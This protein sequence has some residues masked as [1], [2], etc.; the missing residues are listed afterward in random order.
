MSVAKVTEISSSSTKSFEDAI[1]QGIERSK[2]TLRNISGAWISEQKVVV[3]AGKITH[4]RV[5]M[6]V[7]FVLDD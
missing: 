7:S 4:Y 1:H 5:N 6:R 2:K 3:E